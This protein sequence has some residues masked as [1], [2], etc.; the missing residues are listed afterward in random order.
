MEKS[1]RIFT[2]I[3]YQKKVLFFLEQVIIIILKCFQKNANMLLK[4]K[5][6]LNISLIDID[7]FSDDSDR[8][9]SDEEHSDEQN[10]NEEG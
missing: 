9:D 4:K 6:C 10:S 2:I 7:I 5:G 1:T 8:E 3:K